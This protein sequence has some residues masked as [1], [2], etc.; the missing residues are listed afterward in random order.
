MEETAQNTEE[1]VKEQEPAPQLSEIEQRAMEL[2]WQPKE[3]FEAN[4]ANAGKKW[5]DAEDFLDRQ[6]FFDHINS[7]KQE[8]RQAKRAAQ[9]LA[10]HNRKIE[11]VSYE[12]A[13]AKLKAERKE[14]LENQDYAKAEEIRDQI[15]DLKTKAVQTTVP[16]MPS[17]SNAVV[18]A[19]MERNKWYTQDNDLRVFADG[20]AVNLYN[21]G[22][23]DP[24]EALPLI[25]AK[26]RETFPN[27]FRNPNK[28]RPQ[29]L[30]GGGQQKQS[31]S[32]FTLTPEEEKIMDTMLKAGVPLSREEYIKQIKMLRSA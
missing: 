11:Q 15:D 27:K 30:E 17:D 12:R 6:S 10:E 20:Y 25:E 2:G 4:P 16:E 13:L 9:L 23:R 5:R 26:V 8:V 1:V 32:T 14:A 18:S 28:D 29:S 31:K 22:V 3:E 7:L 19:W 21:S 24:K